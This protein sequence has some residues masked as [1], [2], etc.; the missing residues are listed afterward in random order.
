MNDMGKI[1]NKPYYLDYF[2]SR[3]LGG[4]I[5][6]PNLAQPIISSELYPNQSF[7]RS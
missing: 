1:L 4:F 5:I 3:K 6:S 2:A 7:I